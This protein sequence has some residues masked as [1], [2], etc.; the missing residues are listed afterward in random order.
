MNTREPILHPMKIE[1][2]R[3]TQM[4]VGYREVAEKRRE[5]R[6][7]SGEDAG[8]YLGKHMVPV[9]LGPCG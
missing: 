1:H 6:E 8:E 5:W 3:P 9:V 7:R 2:L 4:T